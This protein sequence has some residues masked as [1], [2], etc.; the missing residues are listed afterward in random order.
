MSPPRRN[1]RPADN[2][3]L[4]PRPGFQLL[5]MSLLAHR[6][7]ARQASI[8]SQPIARWEPSSQP[9]L[10]WD[11]LAGRSE[12]VSAEELEAICI[13][14][15]SPPLSQEHIASIHL[16]VTSLPIPVVEK[17]ILAMEAVLSQSQGA[18]PDV[19][20]VPLEV[21]NVLRVVVPSPASHLPDQL[22]RLAS[23]Q[24]TRESGSKGSSPM[25]I[26]LSPP[27]GISA[28]PVHHFIAPGDNPGI[29]IILSSDSD[30]VQR[31]LPAVV[32]SNTGEGRVSHD[33]SSLSSFE[34]ERS[35]D[36]L[37]TTAS[38]GHNPAHAI[39]ITPTNSSVHS[40]S[41]SSD[42]VSIP[43][44]GLIAQG[45]RMQDKSGCKAATCA[46][47]QVG[48]AIAAHIANT[49]LPLPEPIRDL[50]PSPSAT[51]LQ[52]LLDHQNMLVS[53]SLLLTGLAVDQLITDQ[54]AGGQLYCL[55]YSWG[56]Q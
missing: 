26:S 44:M 48:E 45:G 37:A 8:S 49:L 55:M 34:Y 10:L 6:E 43:D 56:A 24:H 16:A 51:E 17:S 50:S 18:E 53:R 36:R 13:A 25:D 28:L 11:I 4:M 40:S 14:V 33:S 38:E 9:E 21:L 3:Q 29:P 12:V 1:T 27:Q 7:A 15:P 35:S 32:V 31:L 39:S 30:S 42:W 20:Q 19:T 22:A 46:N 23:F 52:D 54:L 47:N 5:L 2:P 41:H